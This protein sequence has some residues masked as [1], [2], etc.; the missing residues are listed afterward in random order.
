WNPSVIRGPPY[1]GWGVALLLLHSQP[2]RPLLSERTA[3]TLAPYDRL[4]DRHCR[5]GLAHQARNE[6]RCQG[7]QC[8]P[9]LYSLHPD[10]LTPQPTLH[11]ALTSLLP[12]TNRP[13]R[14][15]YL[16]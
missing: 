7:E 8:E 11:M 1:P 15:S 6:T 13:A 2:F 5:H 16:A 10:G 12:A 3:V 14:H 9:S 4:V